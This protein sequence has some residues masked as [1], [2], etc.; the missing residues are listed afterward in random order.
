MEITANK[1]FRSL[2]G[3]EPGSRRGISY[4]ELPHRQALDCYW[5]D[6]GFGNMIQWPKIP[7]LD[8]ECLEGVKQILS[9]CEIISNF[10][11]ELLH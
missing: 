8:I 10:V 4:A 3:Y 2:Y 7:E 9:E 6:D 1:E 5:H 11:S